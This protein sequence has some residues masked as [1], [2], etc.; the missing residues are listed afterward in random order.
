MGLHTPSPLRLCY[1]LSCLF[2][3]KHFIFCN[4]NYYFG[5][6]MPFDFSLFFRRK[7]KKK[8]RKMKRE[9]K[10]FPLARKWTMVF[11][12]C[13]SKHSP[14]HHGSRWRVG[15]DNR[16]SL[17][18]LNLSTT[19]NYLIS[20][21]ILICLRYYLLNCVNKRVSVYILSNYVINPLKKELFDKKIYKKGSI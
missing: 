9:G 14:L 1:R 4:E 6:I 20:E 21:K 10:K 16:S 17:W 18:R 19:V 13:S 15:K 3:R 5:E 7:R 8:R 2:F 11:R 12:F